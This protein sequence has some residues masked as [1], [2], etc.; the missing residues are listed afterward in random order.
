MEVKLSLLYCPCRETMGGLP[1]TPPWTLLHRAAADGNVCV[2][3]AAVERLGRPWLL[4]RTTDQ[5]QMTVLD[6]AAQVGQ[7]GVVNHI[8]TS[9]VSKPDRVRVCMSLCITMCG[10]FACMCSGCLY[11]LVCVCVYVYMHVCDHITQC[12]FSL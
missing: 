1:I 12:Q 7:L 8:L 10:V 3:N 4:R 2:L 6:V 11:V 5:H 9:L